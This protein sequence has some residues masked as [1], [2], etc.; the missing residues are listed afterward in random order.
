MAEPFRLIVNSILDLNWNMLNVKE[1]GGE[2]LIPKLNKMF[3]TKRLFS[4]DLN[5]V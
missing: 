3:P 1:K 2:T 4:A 5:S